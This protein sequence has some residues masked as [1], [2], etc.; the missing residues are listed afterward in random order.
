MT[1][2]FDPNRSAEKSRAEAILL[3]RLGACRSDYI[4]TIRTTGAH[5]ERLVLNELFYDP[6]G[7]LFETPR[8]KQEKGAE[9]ALLA[10]WTVEELFGVP[11]DRLPAEH[12]AVGMACAIAL[13]R[14]SLLDRFEGET[15]VVLMPSGDQAVVQRRMFQAKDAIVWWR[16]PVLGWPHAPIDESVKQSQATEAKLMRAS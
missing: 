5:A 7:A 9:A 10:G 4:S 12:D 14:I 13:G 16:H 6:T 1:L 2:H 15:A 8:L 11:P 3:V